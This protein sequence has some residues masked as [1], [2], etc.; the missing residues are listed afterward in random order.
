MV[1]I[2]KLDFQ[3]YRIP[4]YMRTVYVY[5]RKGNTFF[6]FDYEYF[7]SILPECTDVDIKQLQATNH[8]SVPFKEKRLYDLEHKV[9]ILRKPTK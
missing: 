5:T 8:L 1:K 2:N 6:T 7:K 4:E 3:I 9:F